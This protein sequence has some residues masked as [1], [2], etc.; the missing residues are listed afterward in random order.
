MTTIPVILAADNNYAPYMSVLMISIVK[1]AKS[2]SFFDFYLLL[3]DDFTQ[4]NKQK[5]AIQ[6]RMHFR[7]RCGE[8]G[9]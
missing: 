8:S 9:R 3:P 4:E 5:I 6:K 1:N 2:N 7:L